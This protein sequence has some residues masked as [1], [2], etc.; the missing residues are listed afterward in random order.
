MDGSC[1]EAETHH[2]PHGIY[3]YLAPALLPESRLPEEAEGAAGRA[4]GR[5]SGKLMALEAGLPARPEV[6]R[7]PTLCVGA[8]A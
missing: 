2:Y 8:V 1:G 4:G 5:G 6:L 3:M 7:L